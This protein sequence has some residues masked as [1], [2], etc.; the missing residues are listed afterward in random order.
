MSH[1][2]QLTPRT[3]SLTNKIWETDNGTVIKYMATR[4]WTIEIMHLIQALL[5]DFDFKNRDSRI[6]NEKDAKQLLAQLGIQTPRILGHKNGFI[7]MEKLP[8]K[9]LSQ[10]LLESDIGDCFRA[11]LRKGFEL[12]KLHDHG[13]AYVDC[14]CGNTLVDGDT[15][16]SLDH[17]L[18]QPQA[19][20]LFQELDLMTLTATAKLLPTDKYAPFMKGISQGYG[21]IYHIMKSP[22]I[23]I[24][25]LSALGYALLIERNTQKITN[26]L[27]NWVY[28]LKPSAHLLN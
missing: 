8:G 10:H 17:E 16:Y 23:L 27:K 11:G 4:S 7:E 22:R 12:K 28:D 2:P 24:S 9:P 5:L 21:N 20:R 19:G 15:L 3:D 6:Q 14:R 26:V 18:F 25:G 13:S 1:K